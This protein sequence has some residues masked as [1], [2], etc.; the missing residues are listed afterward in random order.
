MAIMFCLVP[1]SWSSIISNFQMLAALSPLL[2]LLHPIP[3]VHYIS[4][5]FLTFKA[6]YSH[7]LVDFCLL[8]AM[9]YKYMLAQ[10]FCYGCAKKEGIHPHIS[11]DQCM[12]CLCMK[13]SWCKCV[14]QCMFCLH[15]NRS[16]CKCADKCMSSPCRCADQCL[17]FPCT[18]RLLDQ[19]RE[20]PVGSMHFSSSIVVFKWP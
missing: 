16:W 3:R 6:I 1:L 11:T 14:D 20:R 18:Q 13:R 19:C 9:L 10:S 5:I 2:S 8:V 15:T 7:I 17:S 12:F 4:L